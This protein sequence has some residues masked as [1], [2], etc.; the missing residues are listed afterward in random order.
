MDPAASVCGLYF[1]NP[2]STYF[3]VGKI[4][5][6]QVCFNMSLIE[7]G[8]W[9]FTNFTTMFIGYWLCKKEENN[10][11]RNWRMVKY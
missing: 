8:H 1:M 4:E 3:A 9:D 2:K 6:D 11:W 10:S 7:I 5:K